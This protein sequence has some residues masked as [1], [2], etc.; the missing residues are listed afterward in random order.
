MKASDKAYELIRFYEASNQCRLKAYYDTGS[1]PTIGW[2]TTVYPNG[3]K[4][5]IGDVCTLEQ[6]NEYLENDVKYAVSAVDELVKVDISQSMFDALVSF[7]YN[8]GIGNLKSSTLLRCINQKQFAAAL[9]QFQKWK[10]DNGKEIAGLFK[11]R[12]AEAALFEKG[13]KELPP[14]EDKKGLSDVQSV[15]PAA[16]QVS[17]KSAKSVKR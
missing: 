10:F 4:V 8:V 6:A 13:I 14:A 7:A 17:T 9:Q 3:K 2:G 15:K 16:A 1:V 5:R 12:L 11:R